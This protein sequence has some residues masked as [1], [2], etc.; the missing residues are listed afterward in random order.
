MC[1]QHAGF[2][3]DQV[4]N[5]CIIMIVMYNHV[6]C[7]GQQDHSV[8]TQQDVPDSNFDFVIISGEK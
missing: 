3:L 8:S 1:N 2:T 6:C 4:R 5:K 7:H